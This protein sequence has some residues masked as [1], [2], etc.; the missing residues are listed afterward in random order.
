M[1]MKEVKSSMLHSAGYDEGSKTV[2]VKYK[3]D[4]PTYHYH[5]VPQDEYDK[6]MAAESIGSHFGKHFRNAYKHTKIDPEKKEE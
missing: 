6:L 2:H 5:D 3:A 1:N 4:G